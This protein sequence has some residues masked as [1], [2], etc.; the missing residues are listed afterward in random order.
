MKT[1]WLFF[2]PVLFFVKCLFADDAHGYYRFPAIHG[3]TVVFT[4]EGDLWRVASTGGTANRLTSH[5]GAETRPAIS[6]DGEQVAFTAEYEGPKEVYV[7]PLAGGLPVRLTFEGADARVV[8]WTPDGRVLYCTEAFSTLPSPQLAT[9]DPKSGQRRVL[10]L[11]QASDGVEGPDDKTLIFTRF[12]RQNSSTKRYKG[13]WVES[14]WRFTDG[15]AEA[16]PLTS[17][18]TGTSRHPMLWQGR[19]CFA[20]DRDGVINL[21]SMKADG[22]DLT[23]LTQHK[24]FD[25]KNPK[26]DAGRIIYQHG[27]DLWIYDIAKNTDTALDIRLSSDFD[28]RREHWIKKP[29]EYL[30]SAH[31]SPTGD[32]IALTARGQV[33]VSPVSQG[34]F[35]EVPRR[36][37]ER[38]RNAMFMPDGKNLVA[39]S[40]KTGEL[41]FWKLPAN[42]LAEGVQLTH[43]GSVFRYAPAISPDGK[44]IAWADKDQKL[45]IHDLASGK[46][47][48]VAESRHEGLDDLRWSPNSEWLAYTKDAPNSVTQIHI[49]HTVTAT[50]TVV[51]SGRVES[52]SPAWSTD[53][54]WLYFLSNREMRSLVG[55]PWGERQPEPYFTDTTKIYALAL[56]KDPH[57]PFHPRNE[58][59]QDKP[60]KTDE[61]KDE[62]PKPDKDQI[63]TDG[64]KKPD[65]DGHEQGAKKI[66]MNVDLDGLAMR[67]YEVPAPAGNYKKLA[68]SGKHLL[69]ISHESGFTTKPALKQL[70]ITPKNPKTKTVDEDVSSYELSMDG[71]KVMVRK[72]ETFHVFALDSTAPAKIE[73]G[74]V[75]LDGWTFSV[76]PREEW[77]QIYT[78]GWR[79]LRDHFYDRGMHGVD[80]RAMHDKYLPLVDRVSDRAELSDVIFEMA[81]ELSALHIYVRYGDERPAPDQIKIAS[82]GA[83]MSQDSAAGGW[84]VKHVY[85]TDPDYPD[86]LSPL[87]RA[88]ARVRDDDLILSINGRSLSGMA[89]PE[90]LLR[91]QAGKQMILGIKPP[92]GAERKVV[93]KPVT[94]ERDAE[95]RYEEWELT[96]RERVE[97]LGKGQI[98]YVHLRAMG[99]DDIAQWA[100][101][102]YPV[103]NR[104]GLIIDVRN[105]RGGN[106]DSWILEKLLRR[107]WF[108]WQPRVGDPTWNMQYAFRGHITVLCNERTASDG[109]AFSE[110][111]KRLG[112][113]KVIGTRT[114]GGEIWLSADRWL[115][116]SGM[117]TAA[118]TGVYGPEGAWLIEGHGV[119]P[120]IIQDNLP[121]ETFL[122]RDVQ[123]E[124]GVKH[125]QELIAKDPRPVPPAPKYP[126][127]AV[128]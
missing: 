97:E 107:A 75:N 78:E 21:W 47:A 33:F 62:E 50:D 102:Y 4:A 87:A 43:E 66:A 36:P 40:D 93:V 15:A 39:L 125:L 81:G 89:H 38:F 63:Q 116:D 84:R 92:I 7:M 5:P 23:Q 80:W 16:V 53:G 106:I 32:R 100:R 70:E 83:R 108:Y 99:K 9:V 86:R 65:A 85:R 77:R 118:E 27:A 79:M 71:K 8:N 109:E 74:K 3:D 1:R 17:D 76:Q 28:Q 126:D 94:E 128:K 56:T 31:L 61:K 37:G 42:G 67:L 52:F 13:G 111:F 91:N 122:G 10:P 73:E 127:K 101:E 20:S 82:L 72:G 54:K 58:L 68:V 120:D 117:A 110:G 121:H 115:V 119:E 34:R 24:E 45:W 41:E 57:W 25:V 11:S 26:L 35:V 51:T 98:G 123:L 104:Q 19:I 64:E 2:L 95:L 103:F 14:L 112:L 30:T 55:S 96:R 18:F 6:P 90:M 44:L 22:S 49:Y 29:M 48:F 105:N 124:T 88:E 12:A 113:G 46:T 114:W 60:G 69:W 59:D